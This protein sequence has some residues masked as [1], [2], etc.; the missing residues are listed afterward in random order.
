MVASMMFHAHVALGRRRPP[1]ILQTEAAECG[2]ACLAMIAGY[3][4][5]RVDLGSLRRRF[6]IS[7]KGITLAALIDIASRL[8]L[9][10]RAVRLELE[11]LPD[12]RCPCIL[13][14][15]F[16]HF[17]VLESASVRGLRIRDPASGERRLSLADASAAF[18]GVALELWPN[19]RFRRREERQRVRLRA[20]LGQV[21]G[22]RRSLT[23]V[24]LLA[25]ALEVFALVSPLFLQWVVDHALLTANSELL[26][27]L[28]IA[29]GL[30]VIFQQ[31]T[32]AARAWVL[33]HFG[34]M[35]SLQWQSN[36]LGHLLRLPMPYF[37]KR[38]LGDI[39]SR[40]RSIE[41][42]QRTLSG[43]LVESV[44]DG[45]MAFF[46]GVVLFHYNAGLAAVCMCAM[47]FYGLGRWL[48]FRP[49]RNATEE[50]IV[51][52]AMQDSHLLETIRG[53]RAVKLFQRED[54]RR[55]SWLALLVRQVNAGLRIQKLHIAY[56]VLNGV[57]FGLEN[58]VVI[59][60]GAR[61]VLDVQLSVGM[62]LAFIA[63]KGQFSARVSA[64]IEKLLEVRMLALQAERIGDIVLTNPE[65]V[66]D[67]APRLAVADESALEAIVRVEALRYRY[68][69]H[70]PFVLDGVDLIVAAGES[71]AIVGASGCGKSTLLNLLLGILAPTA[72]NISIGGMNVA[73]LQVETLR[74]TI[75]S[76]TQ[77]DTLFGGS[78]AE[79][80]SF[81]DPQMDQARVE[82]CARL[83]AIHSEVLAM[84][85]AYNTMVGYMGTVLSG[86]QQQRVLL[87][88]ALYK[89]PTILILDEAT[90]HLD[91]KRELVVANAIRSLSITRIIVAHR[92]QTAA[93][94]D[95]I[96]VLEG[97]RVA[98]ESRLTP[99]VAA[100][101]AAELGT[102]A[103][104]SR[105]TP[106]VHPA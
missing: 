17:V 93:T 49:L 2:L 3:H 25:F 100:L 101:R 71:V 19:P 81:F 92:P 66:L 58:V 46:I 8:E 69:E 22:L 44:V 105:E 42:V 50:Q 24:L 16:N 47:T 13:H 73:R 53:V 102:R 94:A 65:A 26:T 29:F 89:R 90:S 14:W 78:I 10:S 82:E 18:T 72:G 38:H 87:A 34:A 83:A 30:I 23:Q 60:I 106:L 68:G 33:M 31:A 7:T 77:H 55:S 1:L 12:L 11:S 96:I 61:L 35:F 79:N 39:V 6:A 75:G 43:P 62:L 37:D 64:L 86:G 57:L 63:Y 36:V 56:R 4:G 98:R 85:M 103:P 97:G 21:H 70:E 52:A 28:A 99:N 32:S 67:P 5:L 91:I 15:R 27:T 80:I 95:R 9:A 51:H 45:L 41:V 104:E 76:V 48:S 20:V 59:W 54:E 88:R 40:F 74:R 84:P